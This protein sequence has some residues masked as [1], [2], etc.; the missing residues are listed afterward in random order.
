MHDFK[1]VA[2]QR[3]SANITDIDKGRGDYN[4]VRSKIMQHHDTTQH[5]VARLVKHV[6]ELTLMMT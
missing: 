4:I 2:K 3:L 1:A 6:R 5:Y